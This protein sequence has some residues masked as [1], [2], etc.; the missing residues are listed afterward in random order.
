MMHWLVNAKETQL[1]CVS[2]WINTLG[3]WGVFQKF[4][5]TLKSWELLNFQHQNIASFNEWVIYFVWN[6]KRTLDGPWNST[7][8]YLACTLK[9]VWFIEKWKFKSSSIYDFEAFL[10]PSS[11]DT[12]MCHYIGSSFYQV[13]TCSAPRHY[14]NQCWLTI[15]LSPRNKSQ[16]HS[17]KKDIRKCC[18]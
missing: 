10:K 1:H 2:N 17:L 6:F 14:L 4:I 13:V 8:K 5:W 11:G 15:D 3:L 12:Y 16:W 7:Q 18:L 9:D